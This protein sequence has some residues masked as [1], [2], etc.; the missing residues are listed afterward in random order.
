[1][2]ELLVG[3]PPSSL[4]DPALPKGHY[5]NDI[6]SWYLFVSALLNYRDQ[7]AVIGGLANLR[8]PGLSGPK[9]WK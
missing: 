7:R 3:F 1:M 5:L 9:D 4:R 6:P 2:E 8:D